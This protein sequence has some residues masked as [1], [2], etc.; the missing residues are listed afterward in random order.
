MMP[1]ALGMLWVELKVMSHLF[2]DAPAPARAVPAPRRAAAPRQN[3]VPRPRRAK[4]APRPK[5][6]QPAPAPMEPIASRSEPQ[7]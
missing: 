3:V 2:I 7:S 4:P 1:L 6:G 5:A